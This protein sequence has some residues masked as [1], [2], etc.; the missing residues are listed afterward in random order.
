[1]RKLFF[2]ILLLPSAAFGAA[3][4]ITGAFVDR[5]SLYL[6]ISGVSTGGT[7]NL[8]FNAFSGNTHTNGLGKQNAKIKLTVAA[9]GYDATGATNINYRTV[10]GTRYVTALNTNG[11][12]ADE[13]TISGGARVRI[14]LSSWIFSKEN[15]VG[16]NIG[17]GLY[18]QGGVSNN[19]I[20][21]LIITNTSA[22]QYPPT[23][24]AWSYPNFRGV[25]A[26]NMVLRAIAFNR[27]ARSG[28]PVRAVKFWA[29]DGT[30]TVTQWVYK[31]KIDRGNYDDYYPTY[32]DVQPFST[33]NP[34]NDALPVAEYIASIPT[35]SFSSGVIT[36]NFAAF[37]WIGD[38]NAVLDTTKTGF[39]APTP[40][41]APATNVVIWPKVYAVVSTN[42]NNS[43]GVVLSESGYAA[44][45]DPA[46]FLNA[47]GA[48]IAIAGTN[49]ILYGRT[50]IA[51]AVIFFKEGTHNLLGA[52]T[53]IADGPK[54]GVTLMPHTNCARANTIL[55]AFATDSRGTDDKDIVRV[56]NMTINNASA[57]LWARNS[58]VWL[59][60]CVIQAAAAGFIQNAG[61]GGAAPVNWY[62]TGCSVTNISQ[63]LKPNSGTQNAPLAINRGNTFWG[64]TGVHWVNTT[65]GNIWTTNSNPNGNIIMGVGSGA[66]ESPTWGG[67]L[68]NNKV[69]RRRAGVMLSSGDQYGLTNGV[70]I[71]QNMFEAC[72]ND[73][74]STGFQI[75]AE[76][77]PAY[78]HTNVMFW[79]NDLLGTKNFF[80]YND[81]TNQVAYRIAWSSYNNIMSDKNIKGWDFVGNGGANP[82]RIGNLE[83][84]YCPDCAGDAAL[85]TT[86]IGA[87]G[88]FL[89]FYLGLGSWGT[90]TGSTSD[91]NYPAFFSYRA[92]DGVNTT[93]GNGDY[94]LKTSSPLF[95]RNP[96]VQV[97]PYDID[98]RPR[99]IFDPPGAFATGRGF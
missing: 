9:P 82:T 48:Y 29:T 38:T 70:V 92:H 56:Y 94:R 90:A 61:T 81:T 67:I 44:N 79:N 64:D 42:G 27:S 39:A 71:V 22:E 24:G 89:G 43:T 4:D 19:A 49:G 98:G 84:M 66:N 80:G 51:N 41:P 57:N 75:A 11:F 23:L 34:L 85:E 58:H 55:G 87:P 32:T 37:P 95:R 68:Y 91:T 99:S 8:G 59:D 46:P 13:L 15:I 50:N 53:T 60:R 25:A 30:T 1:M 28:M 74:G 26:S 17:Q 97:L 36:V 3:G 45:H 20:S 54:V 31:P 78:N 40:L 65:L 96:T 6:Q 52:T 69:F 83:L 2:L 14:A 73:T 35:N 63:G 16:V 12:P 76:D 86:S 47:S 5:F 72:T 7:Y 33:V 77:L 93:E 88:S 10:Y 21:S 62:L 18:T